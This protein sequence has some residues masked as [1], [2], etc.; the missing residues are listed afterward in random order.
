MSK[1]RLPDFHRDSARIEFFMGVLRFG[2]YT[3][4]TSNEEKVFFPDDGITK[5]DLID[6]YKQAAE[7]MIPYLKDRALTMR[8][9]PDGIDGESFYQKEAGEY[10]PDWIDR[11]KVPKEDGTVT[12]VVCNNAA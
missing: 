7:F 4:E 5:G 9:F 2:R 10:F 6:Y 8:R 12:H 1:L 3:V 11:V